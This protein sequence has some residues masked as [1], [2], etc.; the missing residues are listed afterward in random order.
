MIPI[1]VRDFSNYGRSFFDVLIRFMFSNGA[2]EAFQ[3]G[4]YYEAGNLVY[5]V[6]EKGQLI[7]MQANGN[8]SFDEPTPPNWREYDL[9]KALDDMRRMIEKYMGLRA[10]IGDQVYKPYT[11]Q[12]PVFRKDTDQ[13]N[14]LGLEDW[15]NM[16]SYAEVYIDGKY[17]PTKYWELTADDLSFTPEY[18]EAM[19]EQCFLTIRVNQ[20]V[21]VVARMIKRLE[22]VEVTDSKKGCIVPYPPQSNDYDLR[23]ELYVNGVYCPKDRYTLSPDEDVNGNPCIRI[24][25][26]EGETADSYELTFRFTYSVTNEV[27]LLHIDFETVI[28]DERESF[29]LDLTTVDFVNRMQE[30]RIFRNSLL[31][32]AERYCL[33][34]GYVN[35]RKKDYYLPLNSVIYAPIMTYLIPEYE[36]GEVRH[37]S[38]T[39]PVFQNGEDQFT[40]PFLDYSPSTHDVILF[41]DSG[42]LISDVK[43]YFDEYEVK[44]FEHDLSMTKGDRIDF[45]MINQDDTVK[46]QNFWFTANEDN[47]R[48][49]TGKTDFSTYQLLM[50]FTT[51]GMYIPTP[52]YTVD[53]NTI[54]FDDSIELKQFERVQIIT[55]RYIY[56][57]SMTAFNIKRYISEADGQTEF[58]NPYTDYDPSTD[59][60]YIFTQN[61][62]YVGERFYKIEDGTIR[63][64]DGSDALTFGGYVE[65]VLIRNLTVTIQ[66]GVE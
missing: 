61:G 49:F 38:Q 3:P 62:K 34:R 14:N 16:Y 56:K 65:I 9:T 47:Q 15:L 58:K 1:E 26:W 10:K 27:N 35:F 40:V 59:G 2:P 50:I 33:S 52:K 44:F 4:K 42:A 25:E 24:S 37:N 31:V 17:V 60:L 43:W 41:N 28:K 64:L 19:P 11:I 55:F 23:M 32:D 21:S 18:L 6:N 30:I 57:E 63:L 46:V 29:M 22:L 7:I 5:I 39:T 13:L 36:N 53:G 54:T 66:T 45:R 48:T 8:G 20:A 51:S 12:Y